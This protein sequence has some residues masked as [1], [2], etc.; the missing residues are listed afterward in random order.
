M[1][2]NQLNNR[3][4]QVSNRDMPLNQNK[5]G[6]SNRNDNNNNED[7][8]HY[9]EQGAHFSYEEL[10]M[11][12]NEYLESLNDNDDG[13]EPNA[14]ANP[15]HLTNISTNDKSRNIYLNNNIRQNN[16]HMNNQKKGITLLQC[17]NNNKNATTQNIKPSSNNIQSNDI[18]N[19]NNIKASDNYSKKKRKDNQ[20]K[21]NDD[22]GKNNDMKRAQQLKHVLNDKKTSR[23]ANSTSHPKNEDKEKEKDKEHSLSNSKNTIRNNLNLK[24][25][26]N[27]NSIKRYKNDMKIQKPIPK[28][29]T[30]KKPINMS[31]TNNNNNNSTKMQIVPLVK[32]KDKETDTEIKAKAKMNIPTYNNISKQLIRNTNYNIVLF[33]SNNK[34]HQV[35]SIETK[36][37]QLKILNESNKIDEDY[38]CNNDNDNQT[39]QR[40]CSDINNNSNINSNNIHKNI[41][42]PIIKSQALNK[43]KTKVKAHINTNA[44]SNVNKGQTIHSLTFA[45][46]KIKPNTINKNSNN[47]TI[48]P[49][50]LEKV[51]NSNHSKDTKPS[52]P[53]HKK[54]KELLN[55]NSTN[56]N[57]KTN[58]TQIAND[59]KKHLSSNLNSQNA[60][61]SKGKESKANNTT[62][63]ISKRQLSRNA[64]VDEASKATKNSIV[65]PPL[66]KLVLDT[67]K[68]NAN[69]SKMIRLN[70]EETTSGVVN[71]ASVTT[72]NHSPNDKTILSKKIDSY[73]KMKT[74]S[75]SINSNCSKGTGTTV[76]TKHS[77][78]KSNK[79]KETVKQTQFISFGQLNKKK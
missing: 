61:Q 38:N 16:L 42:K 35:R 30:S 40:L 74:K 44:Y 36:E 64:D 7:D 57:G 51:L 70:N 59:I 21:R 50:S 17:N 29:Q 10:V 25:H 31:C 66:T 39:D 11:R 55:L 9:Y 23:V 60:S 37:I 15:H 49:L 72:T 78:I 13:K 77:F 33:S 8:V 2:C 45:N 28:N 1:N 26:I 48:K 32:E 67:N 56:L 24:T 18:I 5:C 12:L 65:N 19:A 6:N 63:E 3:K 14:K 22:N 79:G 46:H 34:T 75:N 71:R 43:T 76:V 68:V 58:N 47:S 4:I 54:Q 53:S 62:I 41:T 20:L 27:P 52:K 73:S 69:N